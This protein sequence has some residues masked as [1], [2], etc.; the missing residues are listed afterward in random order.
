MKH[1]LIVDDEYSMRK[2]LQHLLEA[3]GFNCRTAESVEAAKAILATAHVDLILSDIMM[4]GGSGIDLIRFANREYPR[5]ATVIVSAIGDPEK[6]LQALYLNVYG[7]IIKP[8]ERNQV[9]VCINNAFRRHELEMEA[10]DREAGLTETVRKRTG[11]LENLLNEYKEMI[12][13]SEKLVKRIEDQLVFMQTLIDSIPIPV[14][15][16][17]TKGRFLGCNAAFETC[18]GLR[19]TSIIGKTL[20]DIEKKSLAD[21]HLESD[22]ILMGSSEKQFYEASVTY[23]DHSIHEM[24]LNK[25]VYR[26]AQGEIAGIVGVMLDITER[27]RIE[28]ALRASEEKNRKILENIGLGVALISPEMKV[29][30]MNRQMRE[31][32]PG[33]GPEDPPI[34]YQILNDS[35]RDTICD[36]CPVVKTFQSGDITE[37]ITRIPVRNELRTFRMVA[38]PIH[39]SE[40][41]V[42]AVIKLMDDITVKM[43]LERELRQAQKL[44]SIGQLAAG[45]A[46]EINNPIQFIGDNVKFLNTVFT[47]LFD[48][49]GHCRNLLTALETNSSVDEPANTLKELIAE[50]DPELMVQE[51]PDAIRDT[52]DGVQRVSKIVHSMRVFSHPGT[53]QKTPVDINRALESTITIARNEWKYVAELETD[54]DPNLPYVSCLPGEIN[55]VFLNLLINAAHAIGE[56]IPE[57]GAG[58]GKILIRTRVS[59]NCVEI[60]FSDTGG[61]IPESIRHRIFDPFFT[62]K[63][64]GKGTGQ[65]LAIAYNVIVEK[66][67]GT[68][69]FET[70]DK[71]G[72]TFIIQLPLSESV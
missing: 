8:F 51:I 27:K 67:A 45:I 15:Y 35:R 20:H 34:C 25:A 11:Q 69:N 6:T 72:T 5:T 54:F 53:D 26:N 64:V 39:G 33:A 38:S 29:L 41:K 44:E 32:F 2:L 58:R 47:S 16:K 49:V 14:Y 7:Y 63:A 40:G 52:I 43:A 46:H 71:E 30:E 65:G 56:T 3:S 31:W 21:I 55:Q 24:I 68:L 60:R 28:E 66:H 23:A 10:W 1:I 9:L 18:I 37:A 13:T 4:P 19:R 22:L 36:D 50:L 62:T 42:T 17:D 48:I 70:R 57:G 12:D 59:G 61:G